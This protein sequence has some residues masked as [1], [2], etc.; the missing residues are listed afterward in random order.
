MV[1]KKEKKDHLT[2][3]PTKEQIIESKT[4][5]SYDLWNQIDNMFDDFHSEFNKLFWPLTHK[6]SLDAYRSMQ[7]VL[8]DLEDKGD[9]YE[10][11]MDMPG[12]SKNNL[13]IEVTPTAIMINAEQDNAS[14]EYGKNWV[15]KERN[16]KQFSRNVD[17]PEEIKSDQI[18]AVLNNGLLTVKLPKVEPKPMDK[19]KKV[20][21]K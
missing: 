2:V 7:P 12:V 20:Q 21:V 15:N 13:N 16:T 1:K 11:T 9:S 18:E 8:L 5:R 10:L 14:E 6:T 17:F 19:A 4:K 3:R